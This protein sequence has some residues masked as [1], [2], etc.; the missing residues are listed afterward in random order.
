[1]TDRLNPD[2]AVK[3][4]PGYVLFIAPV[5]PGF[6]GLFCV[7]YRF[8]PVF[9]AGSTM[10]IMLAFD[11]FKDALPASAVCQSL[12]RGL[13]QTFT[14]ATYQIVPLADGG[15]GTLDALHAAVPS[16]WISCPVQ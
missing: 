14:N 5:Y 4:S 3:T 16:E 1:M 15:E 7:Q 9:S 11:S 10:N 6:I 13:V 12:H 2:K 8:P